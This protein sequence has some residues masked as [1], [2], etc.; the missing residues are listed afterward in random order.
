[1]QLCITVPKFCDRCSNAL[2]PSPHGLRGT[3]SLTAV[4]GSDQVNFGLQVATLINGVSHL[5]A[6]KQACWEQLDVLHA[7]FI[8]RL[9][10]HGEDLEV[11][12]A[13]RRA[14]VDGSLHVLLRASTSTSTN[15][16]MYYLDRAAKHA[17]PEGCS[18]LYA[19]A[20][21]AH[22]GASCSD[23]E[24]VRMR[25]ATVALHERS[26][27]STEILLHRCLSKLAA[28]VV[29][30]RE[31]A[32]T[33]AT[34]CGCR[35]ALC[36]S[37]TCTRPWHAALL[38]SEATDEPVTLAARD[39]RSPRRCCVVAQVCTDAHGDTCLTFAADT[40]VCLFLTGF[41]DEDR[42]GV[43]LCPSRGPIRKRFHIGCARQ[44]TAVLAALQLAAEQW[45]HEGAE[46]TSP[47]QFG[48]AAAEGIACFEIPG[49]AEHTFAQG[50][51][52]SAGI[53]Y[54]NK[55]TREVLTGLGYQRPN[56]D[57][58][59]I[60]AAVEDAALETTVVAGLP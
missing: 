22:C 6:D 35:A 48:D 43:F 26:A 27:T 57:S 56:T 32:G 31:A 53:G 24:A 44:S 36:G 20:A 34:G 4:T 7:T 8:P 25:L 42:R 17:A 60:Y 30:G 59:L 1:M 10:A 18:L 51:N 52:H 38:S 2:S 54:V 19:V 37:L 45:V 28:L 3:C 14:T 46:W 23:A 58:L 11:K 15:L 12:H 9:Q 39:L 33:G 21:A 40:D 13:D 50:G 29:A 49:Y 41:N 16:R 5:L 47:Q 55:L